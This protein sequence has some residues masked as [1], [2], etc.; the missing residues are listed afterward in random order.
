V[1]KTSLSARNLD[2]KV[3]YYALIF[4]DSALENRKISFS[5]P[6]TAD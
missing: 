6:K 4:A 5:R 3:D 2:E 1:A